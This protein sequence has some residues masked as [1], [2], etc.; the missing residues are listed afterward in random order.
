[1]NGARV[2]DHTD[3]PLVVAFLPV[4]A[5]V[6]PIA[7][8]LGETPGQVPVTLAYG[9]AAPP[10]SAGLVRRDRSTDYFGVDSVDRLVIFCHSVLVGVAVVAPPCTGTHS[11]LGCSEAVVMCL[12]TSVYFVHGGAPA[13]DATVA[14]VA[15]VR[16]EDD[17][18]VLASHRADHLSHAHHVP[19]VAC[20]G[21]VP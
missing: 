9:R 16:G 15:V 6:F 18:Y 10:L 19:F 1:L 7:G 11:L 21:V 8:V 20:F 5:D 4:V 14:A 2:G 17:E 13:P 3:G 12:A